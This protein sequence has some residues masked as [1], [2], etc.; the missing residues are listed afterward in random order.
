[1]LTSSSLGPICSALS[2]VISKFLGFSTISSIL[3][4]NFLLSFN[5]IIPATSNNIND[6]PRFVG[7]FGINTFA[8]CS[9][10]SNVLILSA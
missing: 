2:A 6:L 3:E 5:L 10:S 4:S 1:M 7:S 8:P 9:N